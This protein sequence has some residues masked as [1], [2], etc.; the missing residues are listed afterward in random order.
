MWSVSRTAQR[1]VC[2]EGAIARTY[3]FLIIS[4]CLAG[5]GQGAAKSEKKEAKKDKPPV[6]ES[7]T[8]PMAIQTQNSEWRRKDDKNQLVWSISWKTANLKMLDGKQSGMMWN[9]VGTSYE[10]GKVASTFKGDKA[11]AGK[12]DGT[13]DLDQL[14]I[15]GNVQIISKEKKITLTAKKVEWLPTQ[16]L[17]R[18][19]GDVLLEGKGGVIGPANELYVTA[20]LDKIA[21]SRDYFKK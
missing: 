21:S 18:A 11:E 8:A 10:K 13:A 19:V 17:Y 2:A 3:P 14:D 20:K 9:V 5:C 1:Q 16:E 4:L 15:I 7:K 12:I 6:Q